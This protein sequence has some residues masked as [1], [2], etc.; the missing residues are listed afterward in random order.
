MECRKCGELKN[1]EMVI[2]KSSLHNGLYCK[3]CSSWIKWV[4]NKELNKI[5][6]IGEIEVK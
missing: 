6:I 3:K 1:T 4:G 5:K 2:I